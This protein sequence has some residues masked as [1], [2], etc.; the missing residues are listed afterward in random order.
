MYS[1]S[2]IS[3]HFIG[4][5]CSVSVIIPLLFLCVVVKPFLIL[6]NSDVRSENKVYMLL[7]N[8]ALMSR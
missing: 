2:V 6:E 5:L 4:R 8:I 1:I 3:I 7:I